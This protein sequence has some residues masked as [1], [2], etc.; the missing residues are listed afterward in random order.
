MTNV[1][2]AIKAPKLASVVARAIEDEVV[3]SGW[4]V[5]TVLGSESELLERFGVSRAVLREAVRI[6]EHS[7]AARMRRGPGGGLVVTE[8]NRDAVVAAISIWLS[9]VGVTAAEIIEAWAPLAV[10]AARLAAERRPP[11]VGP[12]AADI[13]DLIEDETI[14]VEALAALDTAMAGLSGN[15]AIAL[16]AHALND[17]GMSRLRR[18]RDALW[19]DDASQRAT[20]AGYQRVITAIADGDVAGA[21]ASMAHL[22]GTFLGR[23]SEPPRRRRRAAGDLPGT[24]KLAERVAEAVRDD[25]ERE[26]WPVGAVLGSEVELIERYQVSRAIL[27]EAVRILEH[28]GAVRTKR[29][30][31]GGLVVAAPDG[32]SIVR[33]ARLVLEHD[34][35]TPGGLLAMRVAIEAEVA[36]LAAER[37]TAD[38][39][40]LLGTVLQAE[41]DGSAVLNFHSLHADIAAVARNRPLA[42]FVD[43][44]AALVQA[45]LPAEVRAGEGLQSLS[46]EVHAAHQ[47]IVDAICG[48]DL[49]TAERRMIRHLDAGAAVL[50]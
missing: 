18:Q 26:G 49:E 17:I 30:P 10:Q 48:G 31:H 28:H 38:D 27:R 25:I 1:G 46:G 40:A 35:V 42:L 50:T 16:F 47:R 32:A 21:E 7:G 6:V 5:G 33:A 43:V 41:V 8:P 22:A 19:T 4:P 37:C 12:L 11:E 20:L 36:R 44:A 3:A 14:D 39:A 34:G 24:G 45:H 9:Y 2:T 15:P 23:V 13:A 29:G